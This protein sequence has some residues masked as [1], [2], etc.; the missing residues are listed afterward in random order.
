VKDEPVLNQAVLKVLATIVLTLATK[1]VPGLDLT[2][3][4]AMT[5]AL[6]IFAGLTTVFAFITR[7]KVMAMSKVKDRLANEHPAAFAALKRPS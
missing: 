5:V 2:A 1:L 7:K 6:A 4:Q 3:D